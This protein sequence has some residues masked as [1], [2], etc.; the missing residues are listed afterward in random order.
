MREGYH[1]IKPAVAIGINH[2]RVELEGDIP[3]VIGNNVKLL[4]CENAAR[5]MFSIS[6]SI[7]AGYINPETEIY[8][9]EDYFDKS[10]SVSGR[11]S[12]ADGQL[13]RLNEVFE[14][15]RYIIKLKPK[16]VRSEVRGESEIEMKVEFI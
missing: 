2:E 4:L 9:T 11:R 13:A 1:P 3:G 16:K 6:A 5:D 10:A 8:K 12:H 14:K 7:Q 15:G